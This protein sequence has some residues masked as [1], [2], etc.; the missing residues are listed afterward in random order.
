MS[1][2]ESDV[3]RAIDLMLSIR[4]A[5][6][7]IIAIEHVM[8]AV[9]SLSDRVIVLYKGGISGELD[10]AATDMMTVGLYMAGIQNP[11]EA[12]QHEQQSC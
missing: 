12:P 7:S 4:D 2:T 8:Q 6:V 10:P 1:V 11:K 3:R 5:G 9:M